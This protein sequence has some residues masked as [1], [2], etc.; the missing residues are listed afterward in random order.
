MV[1]LFM[2]VFVAACGGTPPTN[3]P[4][5]ATTPPTGSPAAATTP[6][7][8]SPAAATHAGHNRTHRVR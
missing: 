5:A 3:S 1:A 8:G 6:P 7:T 4:A 2:T